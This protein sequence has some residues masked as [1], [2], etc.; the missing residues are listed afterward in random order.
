MARD[1]GI[2]CVG[3]K[4]QLRVAGHLAKRLENPLIVGN[5][6]GKLLAIRLAKPP[7]PVGG[8]RFRRIARRLDIRG[9]RSILDS[10]VKICKVPDRAAVG[11]V[12]S[13]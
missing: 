7:T 9:N 8:K 6:R 12:K 13:R 11:H 2:G 1:I 3:G 10:A 5:Q 4:L